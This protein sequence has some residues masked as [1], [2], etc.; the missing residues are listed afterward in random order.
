MP[1]RLLDDDPS[2]AAVVALV[3]EPDPPELG[4]DLGELRGLG[5]E[6][7]RVIAARAALLVELVEPGRQAVEAVRV[8]EVQAV[9]ADVAAERRPGR[10]VERQDPAELLERGPDLGPERV[11]VV[12]APADGQQHE[13]VRAAGSS[14][15][16]G[17][18][19]G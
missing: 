11:V 12:L 8:G 15:T 3:V 7:E 14:A 13:L 2:P 5:R 4:D 6:V 1:E 18:A 16:G 9:V 19:P 17:T 10:L